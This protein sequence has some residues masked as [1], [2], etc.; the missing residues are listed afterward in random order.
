[1]DFKTEKDLT[2]AL[3]K[4][5]GTITNQGFGLVSANLSRMV[6]SYLMGTRIRP[7]HLYGVRVQGRIELEYVYLDTYTQTS[8][9]LTLK[10]ETLSLWA[11]LVEEKKPRLARHWNSEGEYIY[12]DFYDYD[13]GICHAKYLVARPHTFEKVGNYDNLFRMLVK[14]EGVLQ[15]GGDRALKSILRR[16][17]KNNFALGVS[18]YLGQG[19]EHVLG[20]EANIDHPA[21]YKPTTLLEDLNLRIKHFEEEA[22]LRQKVADQAKILR[23][24]IINEFKDES[25]SPKKVNLKFQEKLL[26]FWVEKIK[27]NPSEYL[28]SGNSDLKKAASFYMKD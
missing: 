1:M 13:L 28:M 23:D 25:V 4:E 10:E 7:H 15:K 2:Q 24:Y 5:L 6:V 8:T 17:I 18:E 11:S 20:I 21:S 3:D 22:T 16:F 19:M 27:T 14:P 9:Q 26:D 12:D